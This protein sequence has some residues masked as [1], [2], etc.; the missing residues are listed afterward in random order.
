MSTIQPRMRTIESQKLK[1][2]TAVN[3][4]VSVGEQFGIKR[5]EILGAPD[6]VPATKKYTI[7]EVGGQ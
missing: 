6:N 5:S 7:T 1:N 4:I 3:R 2:E